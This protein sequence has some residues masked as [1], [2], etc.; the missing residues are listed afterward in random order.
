MAFAVPVDLQLT[1]LGSVSAVHALVRENETLQV[2]DCNDAGT[3]AD[4][5][6]DGIWSC[7]P[8][9]STAEDADISVM[10]DGKLLLGG[11]IHWG[12]GPRLAFL[13][14]QGGKTLLSNRATVLPSPG[15]KPVPATNTVII[16]LLQY[17]SGPVPMVVLQSEGKE[18]QLRCQDDGSFPDAVRNDGS[19]TCAG[20]FGGNSARVFL[21]GGQA[22]EFG[23]VHWE[24][25][26]LFYLSVDL[27]KKEQNTEAFVLPLPP[28]STPTPASTPLVKP[29]FSLR[30]AAPWLFGLST[31]M[32]AA[33]FLKIQS[34]RR[35]K[36]LENLKPG[37]AP[38][39][40]KEGPTWSDPAVLLLSENID[41]AVSF[42][43]PL[44]V[45]R[46]RMVV[47]AAPG[48]SLPALQQ[49]WVPTKRDWVEIQKMAREL[50][51]TEGN[52]VGVL[53][54][55]PLEDPGAL[56]KEALP[57]L[58]KTLP[59]GMQCW[60]IA[61]SPLGVWLPSFRLPDASPPTLPVA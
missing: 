31:F 18:L 37:A 41:S 2:Q 25:G 58:L 53:V 51:R 38:P 40:W 5:G 15:A 11:A 34:G 4:A 16:R 60:V 48:R 42:L 39:L 21:R 19:P 1:G 47:V 22:Q 27:Q 54:V 50:A 35:K 12:R 45:A 43:L 30:S 20:A 26:P 44:L 57:S 13:S 3:G 56:V 29:A 7:M 28:L 8:A 32:G 52:P 59:P 23:E 6:A 33:L 17:G 36:I 46:R 9:D 49:M 14:V 24:K 10:V 55:D 61:T